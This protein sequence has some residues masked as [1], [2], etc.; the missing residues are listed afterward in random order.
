MCHMI[1]RLV[2]LC[3]SWMMIT[4]WWNMDIRVWI[5]EVRLCE[6]V[7]NDCLVEG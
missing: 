2:C 5:C 7:C 6:T 4:R 1:L 3:V